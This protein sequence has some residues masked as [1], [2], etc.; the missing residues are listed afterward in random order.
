MCKV[1]VLRTLVKQRLDVAVEE[2]FELFERTIAEY[3]EELSR[4][5]EE[6][7]RQRQLLDA[8]LNPHV[9]LQRAEVQQELGESQEEVP[10][11]SE[12]QREEDPVEPA[13]IKKEEEDV[14][15]N[16][17]QGE[18]DIC[19]QTLNVPVKSEDDEV[20]AQS[21][22]EPPRTNYLAPL[23]DVDDAMS[24]DTDNSDDARKV[25][26][27]QKSKSDQTLYK[28]QDFKCSECGKTFAHKGS[29]KIHMITHTGERPFACSFCAKRFHLKHH[30]QR[31][32]LVHTGETP[33]SCSVCSKGF[34]DKYKLMIHARTHAAVTSFA[35]F[36]C[37]K[38]FSSKESLKLHVART[39]GRD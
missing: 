34:A 21:R 14:C 25:T 2:I 11:H 5:Q 7:E 3:E 29:L 39:S 17:R 10:L 15:I 24:S 22:A 32:I 4:S 8:L 19:S 1:R 12:Q 26:T 16:L 18:A 9:R 36:I 27:K 13:H 31:H 38:S 35:C 28:K 6:K 30:M 23:S 20:P 33:F 37:K